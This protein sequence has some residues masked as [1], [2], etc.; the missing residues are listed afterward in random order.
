LS[1]KEPWFE[2]TDSAA[3]STGKALYR[4]DPNPLEER[5]LIAVL[6]EAEVEILAKTLALWV[7]RRR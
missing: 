3:V 7:V 1:P 6:P 2:V 5:Y 4:H